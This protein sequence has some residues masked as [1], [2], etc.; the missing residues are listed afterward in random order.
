M[1]GAC[2]TIFLMWKGKGDQVYPEERRR[3]SIEWRRGDESAGCGN[4][5]QLNNRWTPAF[6][7][8]DLG[9]GKSLESSFGEQF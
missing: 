8:K 2:E 5:M 4:E 7:Q 9:R 3:V 1:K 6:I